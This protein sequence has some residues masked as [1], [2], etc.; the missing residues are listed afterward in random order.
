M[1]L[2]AQKKQIEDAKY[3]RSSLHLVLV[4]TDDP[5]LK[6]A[7][8]IKAWD[9]YPFPDKYNEHSIDFSIMRAGKPGVSFFEFATKYVSGEYKFPTTLKDLK[10]LQNNLNEKAY[11][12]ELIKVIEEKMV[13]E[14][15]AHKFLEKWFQIQ[16]DGSCSME[17]IKRRG[18]Y[19]ATEIQA[20]EASLTQRGKALLEDAGEELIGNTFIQ[21]C[22]LDFY[23]NE[24]IAKF[25][26]MVANAI[27]ALSGDLGESMKALAEIA[28]ETTKNGYSARVQASLFKLNWNDSI[29]AQFYNCWINETKLDYDKFNALPFN[30]VF[31]GS[32]ISTGNAITPFGIS[33]NEEKLINLTVVRNIDNVF[34]KMQAN[35]EVFK[36]KVLILSNPPILAECGMKE[37]LKGG[38]KFQLLEQIWNEN[39]NRREYRSVGIVKVDKKQIWDNRYY[40]GE[41]PENRPVDKNTGEPITGTLFTKNKLAYPGMLLRQIK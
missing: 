35:Y 18:C 11:T 28:Y 40:A 34:T 14:R 13:E 32:D 29:M 39:T 22:K 27:A 6:E 31:V 4:T 12:Q 3:R 1:S 16:P 38:E 17:L 26:L 7:E 24:P 41:T 33:L 30:M 15:V 37:G 8:V 25:S 23:E 21:F 36:P 10:Q 2:N 20:L 5:I 19:N 9:D